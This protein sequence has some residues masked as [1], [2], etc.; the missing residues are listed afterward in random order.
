MIL[1]VNYFKCLM[2]LLQLH[3]F[4]NS[5]AKLGLTKYKLSSSYHVIVDYVDVG[6]SI[7]LVLIFKVNYV[8][9]SLKQNIFPVR[10]AFASSTNMASSSLR[11][12]LFFANLN[13]QNNIKAE[14]VSVMKHTKDVPHRGRI[15]YILLVAPI[16]ESRD[17]PE[18]HIFK[19]GH[20]HLLHCK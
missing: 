8:E 10:Q 3:T 15:S 7:C 12:M 17:T 2:Y 9:F 5:H 11:K 4:I 16:P 18:T 14:G 13:H 6:F 1:Q 20:C 19:Q